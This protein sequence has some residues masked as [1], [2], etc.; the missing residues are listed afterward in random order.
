[1][2]VA[3][4]GCFDILHLGHVD[5]LQKAKKLGDEL[6][7]Y[8]NDDNSVSKLKGEGRPI[9]S[10]DYRIEMLLALQCVD[11]VFTFSES[12]P[13]VIIAQRKPDVWAKGTEYA[14]REH[15][16]SED[17]CESYGGTVVY[18]KAKWNFS[19][20]E[21]ILRIKEIPDGVKTE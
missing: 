6:H 18:I 21:M 12:S 19:T 3:T 10:E 7:V 2:I 17:A 13:S 16:G 14:N 11:A 15:S 5:F 1:M 8:I 9:N 20:T 4:G